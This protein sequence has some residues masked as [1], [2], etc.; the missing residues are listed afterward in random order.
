MKYAKKSEQRGFHNTSSAALSRLVGE[1]IL[2]V[3]IRFTHELDVGEIVD[4]EALGLTFV[5]LYGVVAYSGTICGA[6]ICPEIFEAPKGRLDVVRIESTWHL[7]AHST[8]DAS[9]PEINADQVWT[10]KYTTGCAI[11]GHG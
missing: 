2:S 4:L 9:V 8:L 5:R 7:E 3:S 1:R 6:A 11:T 10:L